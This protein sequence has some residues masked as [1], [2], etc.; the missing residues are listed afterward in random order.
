MKIIRN[1]VQLVLMAQLL[2]STTANADAID[3][4]LND[5]IQKQHIPGLSLAIV[6]DGKILKTKGYGLSNVE[7]DSAATESTIYQSG[8]LGK[9]FTAALTMI[10]I[11]KGFLQLDDRVSNYLPDTPIDWKDITIKNLLTHTSGLKRDIPWV[12]LHL[13]YTREQLLHKL[14]AEPLL[15]SPGTD[16][17][18]SNSGYEVLGFI[19]EK[20]MHKS[21]GDLLQDYIFKPLKMTTARVISDRDI[22]KNRAAGYDLVDEQLKNQEYVSSTFNSTADGALYFTVLD[23][24]KWDGALYTTKLMKA[25]NMKLMWT[26]VQLKNG[27]YINYGL[28]WR[29]NNINGQHVMEHGG[30]WQ[31]FT[32][33]ITRYVD[34]K[35][36][37]IIMTNLSGNT[38]LGNVTHQVAS[39]YRKN[40]N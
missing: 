33:F 27:K 26:P 38:E 11:E 9:Q 5:T 12:D 18:Y 4:Y 13:D 29:L 2:L 25:E 22:I 21:Y 6:R 3:T 40:L 15:F 39:M 1:F 20:I 8:S 17:A 36:T 7:L 19:L 10:L 35:L 37:V 23:L 28:G 14:Y 16:W 30:E 34:D 32:A 31:G 24:A